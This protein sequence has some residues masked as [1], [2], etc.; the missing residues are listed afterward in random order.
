MFLF[1]SV[2][3]CVYCLFSV[4][5]AENRFYCLAWRRIVFIVLMYD[6]ILLLLCYYYGLRGQ[7]L[8]NWKWIVVVLLLEIGNGL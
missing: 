2:G 8:G 3:L 4:C 6:E 5:M 7:F 1:V